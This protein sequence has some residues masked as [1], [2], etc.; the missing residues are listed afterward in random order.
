MISKYPYI[1][2]DALYINEGEDGPHGI[3]GA[4]VDECF[5]A[6]NEAF[7]NITERTMESFEPKTRVY[8]DFNFFKTQSRTV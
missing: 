1:R 7:E 2:D 4:Y 8:G 5:Q 6:V 3:T